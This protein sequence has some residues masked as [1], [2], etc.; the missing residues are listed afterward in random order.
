[1]NP[2]K[3]LYPRINVRLP[4]EL[5]GHDGNGIDVTLINLSVGGMLVEGGSEML[6]L[7]PPVEGVPLELYL[8]FGLREKPV[9]CHCRVVYSRRQSQRCIHFGLSLLSIDNEGL[10]NLQTY[11][12]GQLK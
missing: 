8:H 5:L 2:E 11:I 3:R 7:R 4:A 1:M 10:D 12:N 9:H 6:S